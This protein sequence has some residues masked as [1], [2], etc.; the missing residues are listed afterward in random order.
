M[1]PKLARENQLKLMPFLL[2]HVYRNGALM[3]P[4]GIHPNGEGNKIVAADVFALIEPMLARE[5]RR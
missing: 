4:D 3:Q 2:L 5:S 1:F